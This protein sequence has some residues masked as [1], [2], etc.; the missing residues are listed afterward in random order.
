M[1]FASGQLLIIGYCLIT[2]VT[3]ASAGW[4]CTSFPAINFISMGMEN[5][6]GSEQ[7]RQLET[8][9]Q[10][11]SSSK[12]VV[13]HS[14]KALYPDSAL[15]AGMQGNVD[16]LVLVDPSGDVTSA[17]VNWSNTSW[18]LETAALTAA[19]R[20]TFQPGRQHQRA[21]TCRVIIPFSFSIE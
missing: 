12:P 9:R 15:R 7:N 1:R 18:D 5:N 14:Q 11:N 20:F 10:L 17:E 19:R 16:I 6:L 8:V 21:V 13:I 4:L 2:L 3:P